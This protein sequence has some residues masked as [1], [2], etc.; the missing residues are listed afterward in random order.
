MVRLISHQELNGLVKEI[1]DK[2]GVNGSEIISNHFVEAELRGH[3]SH[4]V[5]RVIPLVKGVE[6]GTIRK[7]LKYEIVKENNNSILIDGLH[8]I[9][10]T[11]WDRL[12]EEYVEKKELYSGQKLIPH[13]FSRIL[14]G[15]SSKKRESGDN[16]RQ[17]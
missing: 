5:Q 4:G 11:L 3:S 17:C 14:Y 9:G 1:L 16:D 8:S 6:L 7:E 15:K 12:V 10:I 2:R 13:R